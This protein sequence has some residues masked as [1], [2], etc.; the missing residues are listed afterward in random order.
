MSDPLDA[1]QLFRG[2]RRNY[3]P[4]PPPLPYQP[5]SREDRRG[6]A[7]VHRPMT[8]ETWEQTVA[9]SAEDEPEKKVDTDKIE[10]IDR[11][12]FISL[13]NMVQLMEPA[14]YLALNP[15]MLI[16]SVSPPSVEVPSTAISSVN[17]M[18]AQI[19]GEGTTLGISLVF[20]KS[21]PA[22][23]RGFVRPVEGLNVMTKVIVA[24]PQSDAEAAAL[25]V[26]SSYKHLDAFECIEAGRS[27]IKLTLLG[28]LVTMPSRPAI[29]SGKGVETTRSMQ[30]QRRRTSSHHDDKRGRSSKREHSVKRKNA[31][32][33]SIFSNNERSSHSVIGKL[34]SALGI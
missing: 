23:P 7:S 25:V 1:S 20:E 32:P 33:S 28:R 10:S 15:L 6:P 19:W 9:T 12:L 22:F 13:V 30:R 14:L 3:V 5:N 11:P 24:S 17:D 27:L 18:I 31:S 16:G 4:I 26:K 21:N 2:G 34:R 29:T 8:P